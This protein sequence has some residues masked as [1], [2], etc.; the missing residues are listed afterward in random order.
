VNILAMRTD[1]YTVKQALFVRDESQA[2]TLFRQAP[3]VRFAG[4]SE[5]GQPVLRTL[6]AV[7]LDGALCFHGSD[8]GD[9]LGLLGRAA[10]ASYDEVVA[11]VPSYWIHPELACPASTYYLSAI[12]EGTVERVD[13][14]AYKARILSAL[15]QRFQPEGGYDE[16]RPDDKRYTK[17]LERL[18][19]AQ[20][21]PTRLSAK[22]KLGQHRTRA[23]IE[24]VLAG[25]WQR[26]APGDLRALRLIQEAHPD[27]PEP[28]F[29]QGP[30]ASALCV[31]PDAGDA[32]QVAALLEGQYWT[33]GFTH[34]RMAQAQL[35]SAAWVV[36]RDRHTRAV[37][38]SARV[39]GDQA[40]FG[41]LLDVIVRPELRGR[42]FG[43]ALITLLLDHPAVRGL[44]SIG[45]RTRDAHALYR[46]FGFRDVDHGNTTMLLSRG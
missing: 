14:L 36:A 35:G 26:G 12:A 10:I 1:E 16:I 39:V 29:L 44:L 27:H 13:V 20:L 46:E 3:S 30:E 7:V 19:V 11:Q 24:R 42:G 8:D 33:E 40:R 17:V 43:R 28:A 31:A 32:R 6:S 5:A 4:V 38:A 18:M 2:W 22:Y 41:Y 21:R 9:K 37:L 23:Q 25:L 45:L 34:E 15:M